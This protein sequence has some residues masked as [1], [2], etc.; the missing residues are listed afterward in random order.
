MKYE[1]RDFSDSSIISV[2][3]ELGLVIELSTYGA[4]V[5]GLRLNGKPLILTLADYDS[6]KHASQFFGKTLAVCAGRLKKDGLIEGK[7]YHLVPR[8]GANY[9]L[10]GG[11]RDSLSFKNWKYRIKENNSKLI[12]SFSITTRRNYLGFPGK[13][14][15]VV[16]Y[17]ISKI[18][19]SF[20]IVFS[21][22]A[23][24]EPTFINM[25][26]HIYWNLDSFDISDYTLKMNC[27]KICSTDEFLQI[28]G[29]REITRDYDFRRGTKLGPRLNGIEKEDFKKTI[30]DTFIFDNS[31]GKIIL[32]NDKYTVSYKTN[33]EAMN[34][35]VDNTE[36]P[37]KFN[38]DYQYKTRRGIALEPQKYLLNYDKLIV[39]KGETDKYF[40]EIKVKENIKK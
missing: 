35:F 34:I 37:V 17:E 32:K 30:D 16:N 3:N 20:R 12:V 33:Y 1:I 40:I 28:L 39:R 14:K 7:E 27:N 9:S 6:Y 36:T 11:E 21:G 38:T 23:I 25:S 5:Y 29:A 31:I 19:N 15:C 8:G 4:G 18:T 2:D 26:N 24:D 10:H 13:A 22:K